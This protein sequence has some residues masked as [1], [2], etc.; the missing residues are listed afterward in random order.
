MLGDAVLETVGAEEIAGGCWAAKRV[1]E[2]VEE[3]D[4]DEDRTFGSRALWRLRSCFSSFI[5]SR[6]SS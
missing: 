2:V 4:E 3:D 5:S 6:F 1:E